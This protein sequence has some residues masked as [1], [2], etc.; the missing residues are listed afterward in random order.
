M[1]IPPKPYIRH[2]TNK[3]TTC[4]LFE[5]NKKYYQFDFPFSYTYPCKYSC[6]LWTNMWL[7]FLSINGKS[8]M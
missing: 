1:E 3:P 4:E 2:Y 6:G 7:S 5:M 8:H